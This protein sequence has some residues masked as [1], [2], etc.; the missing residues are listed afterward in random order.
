VSGGRKTGAV[1]LAL[2]AALTLT[3]VAGS[4]TTGKALVRLL[5]ADLGF[6]AGNLA[7]F[8]VSLYGTSRR[9]GY[10]GD[11]QYYSDALDRLRSIPGVESAAAVERLPLAQAEIF[12]M[13]YKLDSGEDRTATSVAVT[14]EYFRTLGVPVI[15]DRGFTDA[16]GQGTELVAVVNEDAARQIG[17]RG[18]LLGKRVALTGMRDNS[19]REVTY[20]WATIVGVVRNTRWK[21]ALAPN[22]FSAQLYT[23]VAQSR[24]MFGVF[25]AHVRGDAGRYLAAGRDAIGQ[26]DRS[27]PVFDVKTMEERRD[28]AL[29]TPR[30]YATAVT[31]F[32]GFALL[33]A[34]AGVYGAAS[35]SIAQRTHEIGV[36]IAIGARFG[37]VR[38][39]L[40]RQSLIPVALGTIAGVAAAAGLGRYV[41]H[42]I[43]DAQPVS[44][45]TCAAAGMGLVAAAAAAVWLATRRVTRMDPLNA[46]KVE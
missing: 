45:W 35:H 18:S 3:L 13:S 10:H 40:L 37:D 14:P 16:D 2:Q 7:T 12:G 33:L 25:V 23:P 22:R 39:M 36:R 21:P 17:A 1:I 46:L 9:A 43:D 30:F 26:V 32:A 11:A 41:N 24:P 15:E 42:L 44:A 19:G 34:V 28:E 27:V 8:R 29:A 31:L 4:L 5:G 20:P 6:R 38:A